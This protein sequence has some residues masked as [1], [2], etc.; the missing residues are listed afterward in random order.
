LKLSC[1]DRLLVIIRWSFNNNYSNNKI[2]HDNIFL[3]NNDNNNI[4]INLFI[5][6]LIISNKKEIKIINNVLYVVN[7][8]INKYESFNEK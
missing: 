5:K 3:L 4:L 8:L 6:K 7:N 1:V 2:F